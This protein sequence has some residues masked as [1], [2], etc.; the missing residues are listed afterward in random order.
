MWTCRLLPREQ[1][2]YKC[3]ECLLWFFPAFWSCSGYFRKG[4]DRK[5]CVHTA[6]TESPEST[7]AVAPSSLITEH[8]GRCWWELEYNNINREDGTQICHPQCTAGAL[9]TLS[10][11]QH[12]YFLHHMQIPPLPHCQGSLSSPSV[13]MH[14]DIAR[15]YKFSSL[16]SSLLNIYK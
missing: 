13:S 11:S 16:S 4:Q 7:N 8:A 15:C 2:Y 3:M 5:W 14:T 6:G 1:F 9:L 12:F 10:A